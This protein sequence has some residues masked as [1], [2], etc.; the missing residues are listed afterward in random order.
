MSDNHVLQMDKIEK[1]IEIVKEKID[2][3]DK[4]LSN[5]PIELIKN[6]ACL[7]HLELYGNEINEILEGTF[8]GLVHLTELRLDYN[9][10]C[11]IPANAFKDCQGLSSIK[12]FKFR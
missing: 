1:D 11:N 3:S 2:L 10:L 8:D 4:N 7:K 9:K 5:I 12:D 6:C